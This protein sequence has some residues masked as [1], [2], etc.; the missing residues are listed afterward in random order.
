MRSNGGA[1]AWRRTYEDLLKSRGSSIESV[2]KSQELQVAG[3]LRL[4]SVQRFPDQWFES[5][6][7]EERQ[8]LD[9]T[10]GPSRQLSWILLRAVEDKVDELDLDFDEA[11]AEL[12]LLSERIRSA[13]DFHELATDYSED[14]ATRRRAGRLGR[15]HASEKGVP[16][17][18]CDAA[19]AVD[20][21]GIYGP[22]KVVD[23]PMFAP[24][25][26]G[27]ALILVEDFSSKPTQEE[28]RALVRRGQHRDLRQ[29][30]LA[31]IG[32]RSLWSK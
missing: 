28:F 5:L 12:K 20:K 16:Q 22:I 7:D 2:L 1:N 26:S 11:S 31:E 8:E 32:M 19:F 17:A 9:N 30:F 6:S 10:F 4:L 18:L 24:P 21:P 29:T 13:K 15:I 27:M 25:I 3:F 14:E 23:Q